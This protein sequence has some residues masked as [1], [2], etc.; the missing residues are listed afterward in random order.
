MNSSD[1]RNKKRILFVGTIDYLRKETIQ[2]LIN[3]TRNNYEELWIVGKL[4]DTYLKDMLENQTHVKYFPPSPNIEQYIHK[5]DETA[6][7]LLGRTTIEGWMCGKKGWIYN[8][9]DRGNILSKSLHDIP[10]DIN[11]FKSHNVVKEIIKEY[12]MILE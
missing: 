6:G 1:K 5:C 7:I 10:S 9:D 2:D 3:S 8:V 4:N 11:K 12:L